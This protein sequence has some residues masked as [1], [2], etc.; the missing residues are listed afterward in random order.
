[1]FSLKAELGLDVPNIFVCEAMEMWFS[2]SQQ[3][4]FKEKFPES[5]ILKPRRL[6]KISCAFG[7]AN[8]NNGYHKPDT[9]T[10]IPPSLTKGLQH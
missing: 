6:L 8:K 9:L 5:L 3:K 2:Q 4:A 7:V 10:N 1:M